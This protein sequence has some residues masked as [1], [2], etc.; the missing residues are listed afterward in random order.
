MTHKI[1]HQICVKSGEDGSWLLHEHVP[2]YMK[3]IRNIMWNGWEDMKEKFRQ[4]RSKCCC[5]NN[6]T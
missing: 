1:P 3:Y 6:N 4:I 2:I 5:E